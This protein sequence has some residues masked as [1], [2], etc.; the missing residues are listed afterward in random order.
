VNIVRYAALVLLAGAAG[1]GATRASARAAEIGAATAAPALPATDSDEV[2][3]FAAVVRTLVDSFPKRLFVDP[4]PL[5]PDPAIVDF[6]PEDRADISAAHLAARAAVL[7]AAGVR[8]T[9]APSRGRCPGALQPQPPDSLLRACPNE[10]QARAVV[11]LSRIGG[12]YWPPST[13]DQRESGARLGYRTSRVL[14]TTLGPRASSTIAYDY[15]FARAG[16]DWRLVEVV[17]LFIIE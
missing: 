2:R 16:D 4:R 8:E 1:C 3:L 13:R 14:V 12:V 5:N 17:G 11:G 7:R 9:D 15:V 10:A 6:Q